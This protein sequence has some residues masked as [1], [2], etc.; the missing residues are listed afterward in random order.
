MPGPPPT[1]NARRRN[2]TVAM[3]RLPAEGRR[4]RTP[5]WPLRPDIATQV[6]ARRAAA[7]V[8]QLEHELLSAESDARRGKLRAQLDAA[9]IRADVLEQTVE[10]QAALER[11]VWRELWRTPQAVAWERLRWTREVALYVR[12]KVLAELG[13]LEAAK[14]SRQWSDRLGLNPQALLRLRWEVV[15][16]EVQAK[17]DE[18]T[19]P[20]APRRRL[21]V[22][23]GDAVARA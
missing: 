13:D 3:T 8:E 7:R 6:K 20:A 1:G 12:H 15:T 18:P 10:D 16:D 19:A 5:A 23:G 9:E 22:A 11:E 2:A 4:G 17:R 14:E 21:K